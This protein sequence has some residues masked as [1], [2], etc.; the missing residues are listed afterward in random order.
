MKKVRTRFAPSPTGWLHIG[1]MRTAL[2]AYLIAK[3]ENGDF[4]LRIE[5]TDKE[6]TVEGATDFIYKALKIAKLQHDEGPD[7]GGNYGPYVQSE[8]AETDIYTKYAHKLVESGHAFYCFCEKHEYKANQD[9]EDGDKAQK[10]IKQNDPCKDIPLDVAKKRIASGEPYVIKQIIPPGT[11]TFNDTVFGKI[12]VDNKT[13][14]EQVLIKSDGYPTYNFANVIDDHLMEITHVVRGSEY[15]SSTPKYDLLYHALGWTPPIYVHVPQIMKD[16]THKLSK[17]NGDASFQDLIAKGFL[18]E[19]IL[20]YIT[21]LG[22]HPSDDREIFSIEDLKKEFSIDRIAKSDA[23]FDP[24][25]L[26]WMNS[27]YIRNLSD[28]EFHNN[29]LPFYNKVITKGL[30]LNEISKLLKERIETFADIPEMIEFFETLPEYD[31]DLYIHKKMKTTKEIAKEVLPLVKEKL[32]GLSDWNYEN[33][34]QIFMNIVS[35][36]NLKN[37]QVFY[38]ARIALSGKEFTP[39]GPVEIANILGKDETL[40]R[41]ENGIKKLN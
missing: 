32:K 11:T 18:P 25:K 24:E 40:L 8:R 29:A 31:T 23:I 7:I 5:D 2:F 14:D 13:L 22:W 27:I 36:L 1:G 19:A 12:T 20:N 9:D 35:E 10:F 39:G 28:D 15:L 4:L 16:K 34:K 21:L 38:P 26:R 30:D 6:R 3:K 37:G 33:I 41:L 17:R